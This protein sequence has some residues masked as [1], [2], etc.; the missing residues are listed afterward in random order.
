MSASGEEVRTGRSRS[1]PSTPGFT[2][3]LATI[4]DSNITTFI[5]AAVLFSSEPARCRF[6]GDARESASHHDGVHGL[7]RS[8]GSSWRGGS[9]GNASQK[10]VI[11][12]R[13]DIPCDFIPPSDASISYRTI[14]S[15]LLHAV[16]P[17]QLSGLGDLRAIV[18]IC[19]I[20]RRIEL[21][22]RSSAAR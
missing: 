13:I 2:R 17:H 8:L 3:A 7:S 15:S 20:P 12:I 4:L 6:G 9:D 22:H 1:A 10:L 19:F 11:F 21:R 14:R 5:A 16:S 18:A